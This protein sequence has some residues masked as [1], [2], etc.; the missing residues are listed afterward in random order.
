MSEFSK[1]PAFPSKLPS[2]GLT[3]LEYFT[4]EIYAAYISRGRSGDEARTYAISDAAK[5]LYKLKIKQTNQ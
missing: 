1:E 4:I 3:K 5:L 2:N